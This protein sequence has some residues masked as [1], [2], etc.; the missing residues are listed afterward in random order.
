MIEVFHFIFNLR[1]REAL[2]SLFKMGPKINA[3]IYRFK[4]KYIIMNDKN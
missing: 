3:C 1:W 2:F 4:E